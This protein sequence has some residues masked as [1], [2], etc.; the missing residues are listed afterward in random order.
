MNFR[1]AA[2][3]GLP[4]AKRG[5]TGNANNRNGSGGLR[6]NPAGNLA[7]TNL[8]TLS[9][10]LSANRFDVTWPVSSAYS[11]RHKRTPL[12]ERGFLGWS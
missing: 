9:G 4:R 5:K 8:V 10:L 11:I 3:V 2:G 12:L 6:L 1:D 7:N